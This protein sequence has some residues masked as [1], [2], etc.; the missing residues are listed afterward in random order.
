VS[1]WQPFLDDVSWFL[2]PGDSADVGDSRPW[3]RGPADAL[4]ELSALLNLTTVTPVH[5]GDRAYELLAWGPPDQRRGW[6]CHPP[7]H[8]DESVS[9]IHQSFWRVCGGIVERFNEPWTWWTNQNDILTLE[10]TSLRVADVLTRYA[11][12]WHDDD[13]EVS[14]NADE[15]YVVA[16]EANG[17][18]TMAHR[19]DGRL[20]LFAPDHD[21]TGVTPLGGSPPYSLLTIDDVPDLK[22]WIEVCA[23]AWRS[24]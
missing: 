20:L 14:I 19:C 7:R 21:F 8:A 22:T 24:D 1:D 6:L 5:V 3:S 10:A 11:W 23:A 13:L 18:L 15:Y 9:E 2:Q 4:P 17:N 16:E 12:I